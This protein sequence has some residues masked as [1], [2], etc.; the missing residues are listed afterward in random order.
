MTADSDE[1]TLAVQVANQFINTANEKLTLGLRPEVVAEGLRNAAANFTAFAGA[2]RQ[3]SVDIEGVVREFRHM[4]EYYAD[5]HGAAAR[6]ATGLERL[7][8][9]VKK[10]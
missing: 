2:H 8:E 6:P 7:I 1:A 10:E 4:L 9:Q 5:L 3:G